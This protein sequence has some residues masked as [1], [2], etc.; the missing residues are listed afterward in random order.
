MKK[1]LSMEARLLIAF[2]LMG[3]VLLV[4]QYFIKPAPVATTAGSGKSA[5]TAVT[6]EQPPGAQT[7]ASQTPSAPIPAPKASEIGAQV[8]GYTEQLLEVDTDLFHVVFSNR[9][10][11]ARSWILKNYK[12]HAGKPL[13]LVNQRA[14][15]RV[16]APFAL[17]FKGTAPATDPNTA[18]FKADRS[19]GGLT[20]NFEFSDGRA[21][22]TKTFQFEQKSYLVRV[23][24]EVSQS[25]VLLPHAITW[26]GGFGDAAV[27]NPTTVQH[28]IYYDLPNTKL[29]VK[30]AKDAKSGPISASG[31]F[32]FVGIEDSYFAAAFLPGNKSSVEQTTFGDNVP[33]AKG[34]DEQRV[35]VGVG[36][37]GSNTMA[38][39]VG[40]KDTDLLR[41]VDP[42]LEQVVDWG[43][44]WFLAQ[45]LFT[46]LA[47]TTDH[48]VHNYGWSIVLVTIVINLVLFPLR[49]TSMKSSRKMQSL[50]PQISAINE[51]YKSLPIRD[52]KQN[53]KNQEIMDLYKKNDVNPVGGCLPM[54][55]QLPFL[56]AFYKVLS[57]SI[58]MRGAHWLW[59]TDLSQ[60]ESLAIHML[61]VLLVVTQFLTQKMTPSP[62]MDPSQQK[63][64]M[65]MPLIFGYMF[66]F[67]S[68]GLVLYW[69]TGNVVAVA[70]QWALNRFSPPPPPPASKPA[71]NKKGRN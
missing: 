58:D 59:V 2:L 61:P 8:Q 57:V 22:T 4:S 68:S 49:L 50:Q 67:A 38:L 52:P 27:V 36:G 66:Y 43:W 69:L 46:A 3:I 32:S 53:E 64:M 29:Q 18:L 55:L 11:V 19:G 48:V 63:M 28:A 51:R 9:G 33:D 16:P 70:Q 5:Q 31:Q 54:V 30:T 35:G 39:F 56:W 62:G 37:E 40:P 71:S 20:L 14:L 41:K 23:T 21:L 25:G 13:E 42:K 17:A 15:A 47:W 7:P 60:P 6:S 34:A 26:R 65:L 44:F 10:A 1:E 24:S 12:D 45:P